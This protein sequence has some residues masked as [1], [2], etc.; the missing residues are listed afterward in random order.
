MRTS[1]SGSEVQA[2][3]DE[4]KVVEEVKADAGKDIQAEVQGS[5][6]CEGGKVTEKGL[7]E[8]RIKQENTDGQEKRMALRKK[9]GP[10]GQK[11]IEHTKLRCHYCRTR[12]TGVSYIICSKYPA[13][14]CGFCYPCLKNIFGATGAKLRADSWVCYVC[15]QECECERCKNP[16]VVPQNPVPLESVSSPPVSLS[17]PLPPGGGE[18]LHVGDWR[19]VPYLENES[20]FKGPKSYIRARETQAK[21]KERSK[22]SQQDI[23]CPPSRSDSSDY[24]PGTKSLSK[25]RKK[26][27]MKKML[28]AQKKEAGKNAKDESASD[29]SVKAPV[30]NSMKAKT[31]AGNNGK[32]DGNAGNSKLD[33]SL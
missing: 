23:K 25:Q 16:V 29:A 2:A 4:E 11:K 7:R 1:K 5:M 31:K 9:A 28:S 21:P 3:E 32:G 24:L 22:P 18:T 30:N 14:R 20:N 19:S 17:L 13:C 8:K 33:H 6:E 10:Q 12:D 27:L 15:R 26:G